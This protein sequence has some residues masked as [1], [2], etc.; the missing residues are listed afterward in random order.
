M[1]KLNLVLACAALGVSGVASAETYTVTGGNWDSVSTWSTNATGEPD[2]AVYDDGDTAPP[3]VLGG[4]PGV[5]NW[6]IEDTGTPGEP[7]L[8]T[9]TYSGTL[10]T[11]VS[12]N[13]ISGSLVIT[14]T[15]AKQ[16]VVNDNSWWTIQYENMTIDFG[17]GLV[18]AGINCWTTVLA[19]AGCAAAVASE[20][21]SFAPIAGNEGGAG[22]AREAA[23]FDG[24]N[25]SI[26]T[27]GYDGATG[28]DYNNVFALAADIGGG[29]AEPV[30]P[31]PDLTHV[32]DG[33]DAFAMLELSG[34]TGPSGSVNPQVRLFDSNTGAEIR[35]IEFFTE[36]NE[37]WQPIAIDT[38]ADA[39][40]SGGGGDT[41]IAM[42]AQNLVTG[43]IKVQIR[44]TADG[45]KLRT[46]IPFFNSGWTPVDVAVVNDADN[47]LV[48][49]DDFIAVL[50]TNDGNGRHRVSTVAFATVNNIPIHEQRFFTP[51]WE[52]KAI[53]SSTPVN[54]FNGQSWLTVLGT[55]GAGVSKAQTRVF[56]D[57]ALV[58]SLYGWGAEVDS[59]D[60]TMSNVSGAPVVVFYGKRASNGSAALKSRQIFS[61]DNIDA[62]GLIASGFAAARITMTA[63]G[64]VAGSA[65]D[66]G[67]SSLYI[68][69]REE[70]GPP[71][72][73]IFP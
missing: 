8:Q 5:V 20:P 37:A 34:T 70:S 48:T 27:E 2:P 30:A 47:N 71:V 36:S 11:D 42:L 21:G 9:G 18:T 68:K 46:N 15:I 13:V 17:T 22:V 50:A 64:L 56:N 26:F 39:N 3:A 57:G 53:E 61:G 49:G 72:V 43:Q 16:V 55:N 38:L 52:V 40:S 41:A 44:A 32:F 23:T 25:L 12:G 60:I 1:R 14:G 65:T 7:G 63:F 28:T 66:E 35:A 6:N 59:T 54:L 10:E 4:T 24:T 69:V 31:A 45:A 58:S 73:D 51:S 33:S 62:Y 67:D 29:G 19:P